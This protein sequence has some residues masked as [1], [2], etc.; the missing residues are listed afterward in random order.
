MD[1]VY[2]MSRATPQR[3]YNGKC[4]LYRK[5]V[6]LL[7]QRFGMG[8][9]RNQGCN[10]TNRPFPPE[11]RSDG[12]AIVLA[13]YRPLC[14]YVQLCVPAPRAR[15]SSSDVGR[16]DASTSTRARRWCRPH[17]GADLARNKRKNQFKSCREAINVG[18][19]R[20]GRTWTWSAGLVLCH[21][22]TRTPRSTYHQ[23]Q[24]NC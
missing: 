15:Q 6:L 2:S 19:G 22:S 17:R 3:L 21:R 7:M 10:L 14:T 20:M 9:A 16:A 5:C 1:T 18:V 12:E 23:C 13:Q 24:S 8:I 11:T 4:S